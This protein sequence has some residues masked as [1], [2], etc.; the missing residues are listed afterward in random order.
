MAAN[1]IDPAHLDAA[2][3]D[4]RLTARENLAIILGSR[5]LKTVREQR[6]ELRRWVDMSKEYAGRYIL[7]A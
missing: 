4:E 1:G 6:E 7:D 3:F 2:E 5:G